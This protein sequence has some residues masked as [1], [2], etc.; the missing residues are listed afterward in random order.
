MLFTKSIYKP[1]SVLD[2]QRISVMSRHT[3]EDGVTPDPRINSDS[4][5]AYL[6]ILAPL[7]KF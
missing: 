2:G 1:V 6:K 5:Y 7:E 4:Y 3:L